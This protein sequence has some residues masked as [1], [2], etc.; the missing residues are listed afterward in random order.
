MP[1][2][3]TARAG[4]TPDQLA[5]RLW[6]SETLFHLLLEAN[7]DYIG[8]LAFVGGEVLTVPEVDATGTEEA[9][10]PWLA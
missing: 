2:T 8:T 3:I 9:T 1:S 6:G 5:Y 7:S 10:P 4:E